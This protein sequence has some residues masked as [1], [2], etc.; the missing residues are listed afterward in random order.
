MPNIIIKLAGTIEKNQFL[1]Q[2]FQDV[3][4]CSIVPKRLKLKSI[5]CNFALKNVSPERGNN[6][7]THGPT[8]WEDLGYE[9][10]MTEGED[11]HLG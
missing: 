10:T 5:M 8:G 7:T 3:P 11:R 4:S 9:D 1:A 6:K 2:T